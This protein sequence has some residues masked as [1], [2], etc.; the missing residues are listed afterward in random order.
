[1]GIQI[2]NLIGLG[3]DLI[4]FIILISSHF[5]RLFILLLHTDNLKEFLA[6]PD[7]KLVK[8]PKIRI[9]KLLRITS[10]DLERTAKKVNW[11]LGLALVGIIIQ[12]IS[13]FMGLLS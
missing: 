5:P 6:R 8:S 9:N 7:I 3:F 11:G 2:L 4:G 13:G 1:M 10:S 12:M